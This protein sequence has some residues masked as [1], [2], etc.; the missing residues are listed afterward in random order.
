MNRVER[1]IVVKSKVLDDLALKSKN[2]YNK[3]NYQIRQ[4]FINSSKLMNQGLL[5]CA[6]WLRYNELDKLCKIDKWS[7][8]EALPAQTAQQILKLLDKNWVSFFKAIKVWNKSKDKFTGRPKLPGYI[9]NNKNIVIFTNQQVRI[10]NGFIIFPQ[11][12]N[13]NP[14]KT[15]V[16]NICQVRIIPRYTCYIIEIVY[17]KEKRFNESIDN[18]LFIGIDLGINNL[19]AITSNTGLPPILINGRPL[20]S[21][22]QYFN[23]KKAKL[24]SFIGNIGTSNKIEVVTRK[25]NQKIEDYLHKTSKFIVDYATQHDIGNI[26]I[27]K[28]DSWKQ[29]IQLGKRNNQNFVSIPFAKLIHQIEYKAEEVGINVICNEESY[30][31]KCS[32]LDNEPICKHKEYVGRRIKRG[33]F[34]SEMGKLINA[35]VNGSGN[36]IRKVA[37]K[38]FANGVE[39]LGLMPIKITFNKGF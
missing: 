30:T 6:E 34:K 8:Y 12:A 20:K 19:A 5:D 37:P 4:R 3:A 26:V 24:M 39:A 36:I 14:I 35:D 29:E 32:F 13:L 17:E 31:S 16:T 2:L 27:G 21:I 11:K 28:N 1:H 25:R 9:R 10:R 38:A 18:E 7:E 22:N 15:K 33:L 23:K